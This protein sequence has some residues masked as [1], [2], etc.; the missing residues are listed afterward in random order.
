[1]IREVCSVNARKRRTRARL[2]I[3]RIDPRTAWTSPGPRL[4]HE[5]EKNYDDRPNTPTGYSQTFE[6]GRS[7]GGY[8]GLPL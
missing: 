1:M 6:P 5:E 8:N 3:F 2:H 7:R 4:D